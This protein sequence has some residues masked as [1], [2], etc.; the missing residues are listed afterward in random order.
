M[1]FWC[2]DLLASNQRASCL[3]KKDPL[4]AYKTKANQARA[5]VKGK[6]ERES[7]L[8]IILLIICQQGHYLSW[9]PWKWN[10]DF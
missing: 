3:S 9:I 5:D 2:T 8:V 7:H 4:M 6:E 10:P 1:K